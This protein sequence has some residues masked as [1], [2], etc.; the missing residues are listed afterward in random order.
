MRRWAML[1]LPRPPPPQFRLLLLPCG[2]FLSSPLRVRTHHRHLPWTRPATTR[3]TFSAFLRPLPAP[4][5]GR[6][7]K[8]HGPGLVGCTLLVDS[9]TYTTRVKLHG[10]P[11][12]TAQLSSVALLD[13][14]SPA[15]FINE[16][17][18]QQMLDVNALPCRHSR[19]SGLIMGWLWRRPCPSNPR[20]SSPLRDL[21]QRRGIHCFAGDLDVNCADFLP[22]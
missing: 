16:S 14:G 19:L 20:F 8:E 11:S 21:H 2:A 9:A 18:V 4:L 3:P 15:S 7:W 1:H 5:W 17:V 6:W 10:G 12:A 13:S 22:P